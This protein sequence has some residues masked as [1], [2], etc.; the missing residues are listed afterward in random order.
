MQNHAKDFDVAIVG[1]GPAGAAAA[2][3][4]RSKSSPSGLRVALIDKARPPRHKTCGGG[5]L[6]RAAALLPVDITP[7][8][9]RDCRRAELHHHQPKLQFATQRDTP[10]V[11]MVMRDRFDH[12]LVQSAANSGT[13]LL[14]DTQVTGFKL[15][16]SGAI[17]QTT[18]GEIHARQVI[19]ADGAGGS[20][21]RVI[22]LRE[23]R[24]LIPALECEVTVEPSQWERF[25]DAARFDFGLVPQ[26]YAW[27][28]PKR[29]HL[30]I[31]VL[32]TRRGSINLHKYYAQYLRTL[33][34]DRP[35]HEK[36]HGYLIPLQSAARHICV[37]SKS[38]HILFVGDALGVA[39]PVTAEGIT[40]AILSG[41]LAARAI[42]DGEFNDRVVKRIYW[43]TLQHTIGKEL[44]YARLLAKLLYEFPR[45]RASTF[46]RHGQRLSELVTDIVMGTTTYAKSVRRP[47][48]YLRLLQPTA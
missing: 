46:T 41:Q 27:V 47:R 34:I 6:A 25:S 24:H 35:L 23:S 16:K 22:G 44:R 33:G 20:M 1:A 36:R 45:L 19:A 43:S 3:A 15:V 9:E 4:L 29:E 31:G 42:V 48:H 5:I 12:L 39:D 40:Y 7:V 10:V 21:A 14:A 26:G 8:V 37:M 38:P 18:A 2:M 30:S 13:E 32:T 17:L 28:F 11:R